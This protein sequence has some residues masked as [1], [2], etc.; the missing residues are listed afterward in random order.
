[1]IFGGMVALPLAIAH[2]KRVWCIGGPLFSFLSAH[3]PNLSI[4]NCA[5][6]AHLLH[7][8]FQIAENIY[9]PKLLFLVT[10]RNSVVVTARR[11]EQLAVR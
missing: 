11:R 9:L 6:A 1:M 7:L 5:A 10:F 4:F 2:T 3:S 8:F